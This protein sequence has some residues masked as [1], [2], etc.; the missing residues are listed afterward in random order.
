[1]PNYS[2]ADQKSGLEMAQKP[3]LEMVFILFCFTYHSARDG[4]GA[5]R[6]SYNHRDHRAA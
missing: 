2:G 4:K 3:R 5:P 6:L 1:M